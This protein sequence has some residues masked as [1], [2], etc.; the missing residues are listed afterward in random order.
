MWKPYL[1]VIAERAAGAVN[2]LDRF[3]IMRHMRKSID[4]VRV[5]ET[6]ELKTKGKEP[7]LTKS[8]WFLLKRPENL[9]EN[10]M[11]RLKDLLACNLRTVRA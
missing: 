10:Q 1:V 4:E 3:H 8:R 5:N 11:D 7:L 9:T 6:K 2:N